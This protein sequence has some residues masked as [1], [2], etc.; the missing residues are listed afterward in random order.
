MAMK[1]VQYRK[2]IPKYLAVRALS[3]KQRNAATGP[4]SLVRHTDVD[5]PSLP[6]ARWLR[7]RTRLAGICGSDLATVCAKGSPYFSPFISTPFVLGHEAVGVVSEIGAKVDDVA[8]GDRV[9][10]EPAL[11][12]TVRGVSPVCRPCSQGRYAACENVLEGDIARGIQTGYCRDT[13][14]AWSGE[15]VAHECQAI[16]VP[17]G[18]SDEAAVLIEPL[19]CAVHAV[20]QASL[21]HGGTALVLGCG[22]MGLLTIAALRG[23]GFENQILASAKHSRQKQ[24]ALAMGADTIVPT[25]EELYEALPRATGAKVLH[26]EIGKPVLIGG[27]DTTFDCVGASATID[28]ALRMTRSGGEVILVGMPA[29]PKGVD[30][31]NIWHKELRVQGAYA[32]GIE[33]R[34]DTPI[35]T[36]T[37]AMQLIQ[38]A[39]ESLAPLVDAKY[40]LSQYREAIRNAL[41]AGRRGSVKTVF[42]FPPE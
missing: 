31:T 26:P 29:I 42:E 3:K 22:T 36:F 35:R 15:F 1:A 33:R 37:L 21:R 19:A 18:V 2:S 39:G 12:C 5:P 6:T 13:G 34:D 4:L 32:Y 7:V 11:H 40:P 28:D 17:D 8:V 25:G 41:N 27:V 30:W 24:L 10:I 38:D 16:K 23:L 20:L 14:G 9:V